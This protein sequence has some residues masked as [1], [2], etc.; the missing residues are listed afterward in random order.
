MSCPDIVPLG[1]RIGGMGTGESPDQGQYPVMSGLQDKCEGAIGFSVGDACEGYRGFC[2]RKRLFIHPEQQEFVKHLGAALAY[3]R[4]HPEST[5]VL[6]AGE[7][8]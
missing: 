3:V 8:G 5:N 2:F 1:E 7:D 6:I 4:G